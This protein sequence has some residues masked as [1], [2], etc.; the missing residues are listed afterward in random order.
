VQWIRLARD[1]LRAHAA[2]GLAV[3]GRLAFG[4]WIGAVLLA[5]LPPLWLLVRLLPGR[6]VNRAVRAWSRIVLWL[7]GCRLRVDGV[8]H[9]PAAG[10][11]VFAANHASYLDSV[12]LFAAI[13]RDFRFVGKRELLR[14]PLVGSVIRR[15][16]HLTV[17]LSAPP[18]PAASKTRAG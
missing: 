12:T 7:A 1:S 3:A 4:A 11:A 8:E 5:T 13:P 10:P 18:R 16:A 15:S 9:V 2:R 17:E 6:A 14:W